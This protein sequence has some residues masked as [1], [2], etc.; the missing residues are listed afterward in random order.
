MVGGRRPDLFF[1]KPPETC[2]TKLGSVDDSM[3][4]ILNLAHTGGLYLFIYLST[5]PSIH[6]SI[7]PCIRVVDEHFVKQMLME[8]RCSLLRSEVNSHPR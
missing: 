7:L 2:K 8:I 3:T 6:S 1:C 5:H 4:L